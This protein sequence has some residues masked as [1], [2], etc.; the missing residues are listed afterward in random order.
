MKLRSSIVPIVIGS[1]LFMENMDSTVIATS[2]PAIAVDL[3][4]EPIILK[5]A[6]TAY[7]ISL[8]VFIPISGW[9]ADRLGAKNVFRA[10]I[11]VFTLGSIACAMTDSL[12]GFIVARALQGM[13]GAMMTPVGRLIL[14][15][16][17][18]KSGFVT[19]MAYMTIPAMVGPMMGPP[20]G[21]FITTY[22]HWRW[23]FWINVP[24]G[25]LAI[26]LASIFMSNVRDEDHVPLDALGFLLSGIGL[27][28]LIF[29]LTIIRRGV[30][31]N[32]GV[33]ALI[34]TG[35]VLL[36]AYTRH[37]RRIANP[38]LDLRLLSVQTFASG[39][40]GGS[41]FRIGNG[42][43]PFLLP[44]MLQVGFGLNALESGSLTFAGAAGALVM[45]FVGGP[46]LRRY[47]FRKVL[48]RNAL[49]S[50]VFI[51]AGAWF[52]A[53][54]PHLVILLV[55][56]TG[57]FF[58]SLQFTGIN[59]IAYADVVP[60]HMSRATSLAS[61]AQQI[62]IALGI[63]ATAGIL[64]VGEVVRGGHTLMPSDF[65]A[66]FVFVGLISASSALVHKRLPENAGHELSGHSPSKPAQVE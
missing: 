56:L 18:P 38:I 8:A 41:L 21:G 61:V 7:L 46:I 63:A 16:A 40:I 53:Q 10:A 9:C 42:A 5:L 6:F 48:V 28:S 45:K 47:G 60:A 20:I 26:T 2:L 19:A 29:G 33:A 25:L 43:I 1:A 66:A 14:L 54:T 15:R 35:I 36:F 31:P 49:L 32:A 64:E 24:M 13:G 39:V 27:A 62:A 52:T 22:F 11:G 44:L 59:S 4:L 34:A 50:A 55:L 23:I 37:A 65:V 17:V 51:S 12:A 58:R 3:G 30:L 57:G